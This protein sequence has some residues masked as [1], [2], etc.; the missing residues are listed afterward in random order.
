MHVVEQRDM[1]VTSLEKPLTLCGRFTCRKSSDDT[2]LEN[3]ETIPVTPAKVPQTFGHG[4]PWYKKEILNSIGD[5]LN[6][7]KWSVHTIKGD[8]MSG[9]CGEKGCT[10]YDFFMTIFPLE[11]PAR[12]FA[13]TSSLLVRIN[14]TKK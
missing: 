1:A 11:H 8:A 6:S 3:F 5:V 4:I 7:K 9:E 10:P 14:R 13:M 12:I 2:E